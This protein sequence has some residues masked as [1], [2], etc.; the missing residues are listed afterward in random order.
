MESLLQLPVLPL[1]HKLMDEL[2]FGVRAHRAPV[3]LF[4]EGI[5][6]I[7]WLLLASLLLLLPDC[8][9]LFC[10]IDWS[11]LRALPLIGEK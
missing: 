5:L 3:E 7:I 4:K 2:L 8:S 10:D 6:T 11:E 1:L 9:S